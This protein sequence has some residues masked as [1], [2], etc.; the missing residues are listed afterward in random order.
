MPSRI[1]CGNGHRL[2]CYRKHTGESPGCTSLGTIYRSP[3]PTDGQPAGRQALT[4]LMSPEG[5][6]PIGY[7]VASVILW[8]GITCIR[9]SSTLR[10][11]CLQSVTVNPQQRSLK[12]IILK[13]CCLGTKEN[14]EVEKTCP[15]AHDTTG[16]YFSTCRHASDGW[17]TDHH[18]GPMCRN[19]RRGVR[20]R[21]LE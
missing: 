13:P 11:Y 12:S 5:R 14:K 15:S 10:D 6:N 7:E 19:G 20:I 17:V 16:S 8:E 21:T 2:P 18:L 4:S 9:F 3:D 1:P